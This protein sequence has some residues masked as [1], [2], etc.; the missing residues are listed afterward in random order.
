MRAALDRA[1]SVDAG[2]PLAAALARLDDSTGL[3]WLHRVLASNRHWHLQRGVT[4][5][6]GS[7]RHASSV[8]PLLSF[9]ARRGVDPEL[10]R[11]AVD[12]LRAYESATVWR[13][14][15]ETAVGQPELR[16]V[17]IDAADSVAVADPTVS[18]ALGDWA[19]QLLGTADA[20]PRLDGAIRLASR[21]RPHDA[22]PA[23]VRAL[24]DSVSGGAAAHE[25]VRLTAVENAPVLD[26]WRGELARAAARQFWEA[27]L[28]ANRT[29][30]RV[31]PP[32][33]GERAYRAWLARVRDRERAQRQRG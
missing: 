29:T 28:A 19:L 10:R 8:S 30:Y 9:A 16:Q 1:A 21:L 31:A 3:A 32:D 26:P 15:V 13:R 11:A 25:L 14:M 17:V 24:A 20:R 7:I 33:V 5:T 12:A 6:L 4:A 22:V 23:L 18:R 27:W 2:A